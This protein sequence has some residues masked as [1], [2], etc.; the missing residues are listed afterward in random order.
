MTLTNQKGKL[1]IRD[2][3][4]ARFSKNVYYQ[5]FF[6]VA[7][8]LENDKGGRSSAFVKEMAV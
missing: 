7:T 4:P 6:K 5:S 2:N 8:V 1:I 3:I